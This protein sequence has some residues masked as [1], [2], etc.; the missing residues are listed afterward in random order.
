M[1]IMLY[2]KIQK[3]R[4]FVA[5]LF[6]VYRLRTHDMQ[7]ICASLIRAVTRLRTYDMQYILCVSLIRAVTTLGIHDLQYM[8]AYLIRAVT[9]LCMYDLH[10]CVD[11]SYVQLNS[12]SEILQ[13][14][15]TTFYEKHIFLKLL[16]YCTLKYVHI[17]ISVLM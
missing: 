7:Y 16:L 12:Q 4:R 14:E 2:R 3:L 5:C 13:I 10:V 6:A 17:W 11:L 1:L 8:C 9:R 15:L